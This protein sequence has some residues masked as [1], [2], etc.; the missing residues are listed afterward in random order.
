MANENAAHLLERDLV[1]RERAETRVE[2]VHR[3]AARQHTVDHIA[4]RAHA[5]QRVGV[6]RDARASA[7]DGEHV[8][9]GQAVTAEHDALVG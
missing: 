9:D 2:S 5:Q 4:C 8:V 1:A 3:L 7:R 6:E